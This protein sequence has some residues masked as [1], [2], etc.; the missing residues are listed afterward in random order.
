MA[1]S[2]KNSRKTNSPDGTANRSGLP[3]STVQRANLGGGK[4]DALSYSAPDTVTQ[5]LTSQSS[6]EAAEPIGSGTDEIALRAYYL[7]ERR[8]SEG[9]DGDEVSDWLQAEN[10]LLGS[11]RAQ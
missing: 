11:T 2:T 4:A 10:E 8:R 3:N 5:E 7:G 6:A 9:R 1:T